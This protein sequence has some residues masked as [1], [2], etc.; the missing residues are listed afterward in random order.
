MKWCVLF[1]FPFMSLPSMYNLTRRIP[2]QKKCKLNFFEL[3]I[4]HATFLRRIQKTNLDCKTSTKTMM[5]TWLLTWVAFSRKLWSF[6]RRLSFDIGT[7]CPHWKASW[8]FMENWSSFLNTISQNKNNH[9]FLSSLWRRLS[10]DIRI[11]CPHWKSIITFYGKSV[12]FLEHNF[13]KTKTE[14][15]Y[16]GQLFCTFEIVISQWNDL[17]RQM[18]GSPGLLPQ[19]SNQNFPSY[20]SLCF[21][22]FWFKYS[23]AKILLFRCTAG[24]NQSLVLAFCCL[25]GGSNQG[26]VLRSVESGER[27]VILIE[28]W[29]NL[30]WSSFL[31]PGQLVT[32]IYPH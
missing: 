2:H 25:I 21:D 26:L 15:F 6:C 31:T 23:K 8:R 4:Q 3:Q 24:C 20:A 16:F 27:T 5:N 10:F 14:H 13:T 7:N 17:Y 22:L 11:N 1:F 32:W 29:C 28:K 18:A 19:R 9:F 12:L 30:L